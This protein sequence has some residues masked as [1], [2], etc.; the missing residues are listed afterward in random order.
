VTP[1]PL[2]AGSSPTAPPHVGEVVGGGRA[3]LAH[4]GGPGGASD[5]SRVAVPVP[6][7]GVELFGETPGSGYRQPPSLVRRLDGQTIQLTPL[8]YE[9]LRAIDGRRDLHAIATLVGERIDRTVSA[10]DVLYLAEGKLRPLGLLREHD[11]SEPELRKANPLLALSCRVVITDPQVTRR[12]TRP[13]AALF[14]PGLV[15]LFTLAFIAVTW[16]TFFEQGMAASIHQAFYEPHLLLLVFALTLVSAGFHEFG[17]AAACR[18]GGATPGAMGFG[19][20]L[21]WPAFYTDVTDSYRLGR[22]ARLRVDLGGLYFNMVFAVGT[23]AVWGWLRADALLLLIVAQVLQMARQLAPLVRFDGY[24][25]LADLTGVPDLF[26]HI[27][28]TLLG[29]LPSRWRSGQEQ[30]LKPWARAVVTLW[31]LVVVP[32]LAVMLITIVLILPRLAVTAWDSL[33]VQWQVLGENWSDRAFADV[34][35]RLLSMISLALPVLMVSYLLGRVARRFGRWLWQ[36]GDGSRTTRTAAVLGGAAVL[37]AVA[38]AWWPQ[39]PVAP[40]EAEEQGTLPEL[41]ALSSLPAA[42]PVRAAADVPPLAPADPTPQAHPAAEAAPTH[43]HASVGSG[44]TPASRD[45][46]VAGPPRPGAGDVPARPVTVPAG[47]PATGDEAAGNAPQDAPPASPPAEGPDD[48]GQPDDLE[49]PTDP[50]EPADLEEPTDPGGPADAEE[51]TDP[52]GPADLEE[53][54]DPGGPADAEEPTDPGGPADAEEPTDEEERAPEA[55]TGEDTPT[56]PDS[57]PDWPFPWDAPLPAGEGDNRATVVN[58]EDGSSL[59]DVSSSLV[60]VHD[61]GPVAQRNEA[62]AYASCRDCRSLAAAF[63]VVLIIGQ[64]NVIT[65]VNTAVAANYDCEACTTHAFA[66]QLV[67]TLPAVPGD[68]TLMELAR[69]WSGLE[70]LEQHAGMLTPEQIYTWLKYTEAQILALLDDAGARV[71]TASE[72]AETETTEDAPTVDDPAVDD[73]VGADEEGGEPASDATLADGST[74]DAETMDAAATDTHQ[75]PEGE[76]EPEVSHPDEELGRDADEG[77]G[78]STEAATPPEEGDG[79]EEEL[80]KT[81]S[82]G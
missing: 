63:Q 8:L 82:E 57:A 37:A 76:D 32:L 51:P 39:G 46:G 61:G 18:Y 45:G 15:M 13:F 54:T 24:H 50:G 1:P 14:R 66:V 48:P 2:D 55:P 78:S 79:S 36:V 16:W 69:L 77:S 40:F 62:F 19:L 71:A 74:P 56:N 31:V 7:E 25:I 80:E 67:A 35:I 4:P 44:V 70:Q 6:A 23:F 43:P 10:A 27:K 47:P 65:P 73:T 20:Y 38:F 11:G 5:L 33:G 34:G 49:E 68:E 28:P 30:A 52:G 58:T 29:M 21:I 81:T 22:A 59:H 9:V 42:E 41:F 26:A 75:V 12:L 64:A 3:T 17:H 53:P 60:W 72:N